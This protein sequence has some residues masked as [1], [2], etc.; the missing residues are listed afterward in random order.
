MQ[1][2]EFNLVEFP[3]LSLKNRILVLRA[4]AALSCLI[5]LFSI[6]SPFLS[7]Q[8]PNNM[9]TDTT[10]FWSF[11]SY[12]EQIIPFLRM[13]PI[14]YENWFLDYWAKE[15]AYRSEFL[16]LFPLMFVAQ[17]LTLLVGVT[18]VMV[19]KRLLVYVPPV[20]CSIIIVLMAYVSMS[21][22][23]EWSWQYQ[24]GFWLI[25]VSFFSF[26]SVPIAE[27]EQEK[28]SNVHNMPEC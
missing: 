12:T 25:L 3:L 4:L 1:D 28:I 19:R 23:I 22:K 17:V 9:F 26:L 14:T 6:I 16:V 27:Y 7:A 5:F 13:T 20:L 8:Y 11:K 15:S 18:T 2:A 10:Q 24:Q 21:S